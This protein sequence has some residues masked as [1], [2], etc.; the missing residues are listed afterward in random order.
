[1]MIFYFSIS[2]ISN[3]LKHIPECW[4]SWLK[5]AMSR[6]NRP[7]TF[8]INYFSHTCLSSCLQGFAENRF[9]LWSWILVWLWRLGI[10]SFPRHFL[11]DPFK[12]CS[13]AVSS[14]EETCISL[15]MQKKQIM[16]IS[17]H[18]KQTA[19]ANLTALSKLCIVGWSRVWGWILYEVVCAEK[20][21]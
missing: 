13:P 1:M 14:R 5:G 8:W 16:L 4:N 15:V 9:N 19:L 10:L 18:A 2:F 3:F 12:P 17:T 6:T 20:F 11:S 21:G 7:C